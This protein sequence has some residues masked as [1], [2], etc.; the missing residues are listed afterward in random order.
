MNIRRNA[1]GSSHPDVAISLNC[2]GLFYNARQNYV[3]AQPL[4]IEALKIRQRHESSVLPDIASSM[5]NVELASKKLEI[6]LETE[7]N[8]KTIIET[9]MKHCPNHPDL[10]MAF[11]RLGRFYGDAGEEAKSKECYD[12]CSALRTR[13]AQIAYIVFDDDERI[14]GRLIS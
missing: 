8:L 11:S 1:F 13:P 2:L 3:R 9:W 7:H 4:L 6:N 10:P 5:F 12:N 14:E